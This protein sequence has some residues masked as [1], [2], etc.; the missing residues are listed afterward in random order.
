MNCEGCVC[1]LGSSWWVVYVSE[2][3][4]V[5]VHFIVWHMGSVE[6]WWFGVFLVTYSFEYVNFKGLTLESGVIG[7]EF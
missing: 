3:S 6:F 5:G 1:N 7:L 2:V 4:G